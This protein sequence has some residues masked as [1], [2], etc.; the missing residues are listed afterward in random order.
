[1]QRSYKKPR[2]KRVKPPKPLPPPKPSRPKRGDLKKIYKDLLTTDREQ[3]I[4]TLA[5]AM[6]W[7]DQ[8]QAY[9]AYKNEG[10]FTTRQLMYKNTS[11]KHRSDGIKNKSAT[12]KELCFQNSILSYE[13]MV[14][15]YKPPKLAPILKKLKSSKSTLNEHRTNMQKKH[16]KFLTQLK[17]ALSLNIKVDKLSTPYMIGADITLAK[18]LGIN[19]RKVT[20][21]HGLLSAIVQL[22]PVTSEKMSR[23]A[24]VDNNGNKT[25]R[26]KVDY[27]QRYK[28]VLELLNRFNNYA[29]KEN[30]PR[31]IVRK[32]KPPQT[33]TA[34]K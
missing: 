1:M 23:Y 14:N 30:A 29:Q 5:K 8:V 24:E 19:W 18:R 2:V 9:L 28:A 27:H 21:K 22:L 16:G 34:E 10:K 33:T 26:Y 12:L 4:N 3:R 13:F 7:Y 25:G 11:E 20:R 15:G 32:A 17:E 6:A 31:S